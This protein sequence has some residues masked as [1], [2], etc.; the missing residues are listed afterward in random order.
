VQH[1]LRTSYR[2]EPDIQ[3]PSFRRTP[4][5]VRRL[6]YEC[7]KDGL[8]WRNRGKEREKRI[9]RVGGKLYPEGELGRGGEREA[10]A[11]E[12]VRAGR[13]FW[14]GELEI[15]ENWLMEQHGERGEDEWEGHK[16]SFG[17]DRPRLADV[18]R[19]LQEFRKE[20]LDT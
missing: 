19:M 8:D 14:E 12:T 16:N 10:S 13:R 20:C 3:F 15:M 2:H 9:T 17:L 11:E 1:S 6:I 4:E 5:T 18:L 7:T